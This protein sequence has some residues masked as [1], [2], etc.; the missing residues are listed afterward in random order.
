MDPNHFLYCYKVIDLVFDYVTYNE[1]VFRKY[2]KRPSSR[3]PWDK[4]ASYKRRKN[5]ETTIRKALLI[6]Q[7]KNACGKMI[8]C[9]YYLTV[10]VYI[11]MAANNII[12]AFRICLLGSYYFRERRERATKTISDVMRFRWCYSD[13]QQSVFLL[14]FLLQ[15]CASFQCVH[16]PCIVDIL[17]RRLLRPAFLH[18][19][20]VLSTSHLPF[21]L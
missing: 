20:N 19:N 16:T 9:T 3:C 12:D 21:G 8:Q 11:H 18:F 5:V 17:S 1:Q 15:F 6:S 2:D 7:K 10:T 4:P 14:S 13:C